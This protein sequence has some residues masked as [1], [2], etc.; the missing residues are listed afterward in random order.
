[1]RGE[2]RGLRAVGRGVGDERCTHYK[3][4]SKSIYVL[5]TFELSKRQ[6]NKTSFSPNGRLKIKQSLSQK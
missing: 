4:Y 6:E 3:Y 5:F 2:W 1:M